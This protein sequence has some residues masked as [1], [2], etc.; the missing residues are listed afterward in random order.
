MNRKPNVV[1]VFGDQWRA[2]ACGYAG[3]HTVRTPAIDMF[4]S[5]SISL[6]NAASGCPV[7]SPYRASL[8][9]GLLPLNHGVFV[10]DVPIK[11]GQRGFGNMFADAGYDTAYVGKWHIGAPGGRRKPV[12]RSRRLGFEYWKALE[13]THRYNDSWY[14][15]FD[16]TEPRV[17]D[18]YDAA[19]QT[20]DAES[21]VREHAGGSP[22]ALVL[23]WGPP[24]S[25]YDTAPEEYRNMYRPEDIQLRPNV[26]AAAAERA[27]KDLAGYYAH[28][29]ALD[30]CFGSLLRTLDETGI[31]DD[32]ILVFTSDHG[33][34]LGSQGCQRK[35]KPWEESVRV[36]FLVRWPAG[37]GKAGPRT[38][39][40]ERRDLH[41][42]A[43]DVLPTL[44][45]LC[46][47]EV[48]KPID[49]YDFS[50][51]LRGEAEA[52]S[53]SVVLACYHP[54]GEWCKGKDGGVHGYAGR[55]YRGLRTDRY[56]Y[57]RSLADGP[58]LLY[59]NERD[60]YQGTNLVADDACR[61]VREEL[62]TKLSKRLEERGD[63]FLE[64]TEYLDQW[65]YVVDENGTVPY[66]N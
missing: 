12:P 9:T 25:P 26:P 50:P 53:D 46:G 8:L 24:H 55:E 49:G 56:T 64:G 23:S 22:F 21:Y 15:A 61:A 4:A 57:V 52:P 59:D 17:W 37:L 11:D 41:V 27:R 45:G 28:C 63:E 30:A 58:W 19:A 40:G 20:R 18:G 47:I 36:P 14:Y 3:N 29:S 34:M 65:G 10:N 13:C 51:A 62:D 66:Q 7:C 54:F 39:G 5:E 35:Q 33:D 60:P 32:T 48:Q 43:Q 16:E 38:G 6:P 44:L 1:I 31:A 2:Q 42:D